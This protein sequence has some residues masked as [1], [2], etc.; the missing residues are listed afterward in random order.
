M[1]EV[2]TNVFLL[3]TTKWLK[4][5]QEVKTIPTVAGDVAPAPLPSFQHPCHLRWHIVVNPKQ[6]KAQPKRSLEIA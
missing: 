6:A 2:K 4:A 3:P 5:I 1:K